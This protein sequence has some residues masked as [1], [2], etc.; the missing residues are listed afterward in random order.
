MLGIT[1]ETDQCQVATAICNVCMLP[2]LSNSGDEI[3]QGLSSDSAMSSVLSF[4]IPFYI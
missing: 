1:V 2:V 3:S 4:A